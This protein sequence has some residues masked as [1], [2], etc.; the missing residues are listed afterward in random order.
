MRLVTDAEPEHLQQCAKVVDERLREVQPAPG[1]AVSPRA[2][3]LVALGLAHDLEQ[4]LKR[5]EELRGAADGMLN[6]LLRRVDDALDRVDADGI[7]LPP[8]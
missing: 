7:A 8:A 5:R 3:L 4:E 2:L 6:T 1:S